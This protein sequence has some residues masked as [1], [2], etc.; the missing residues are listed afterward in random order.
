MSDVWSYAGKQC[1]VCGCTSGMGAATARELIDLGAEVTGL[2][3]RATEV[4]VKE[5]IPV[6]LSDKA[7]IDTALEQTPSRVDAL[8]VCSGL[9]G[10]TKW[11]GSEV[12]TVNFIGARHLVEVMIDKLADG[13]AV[14]SIASVAGMGFQAHQAEIMELLRAAST[15][16]D[17]A[18][19]CESHPELV[20][21]GYAFSK[22]CLI[23]YTMWRSTDLATRGVRINCI[24]PGPTD[25][26]MMP[27]FE[28]GYGK[29]YMQNFPKPVG[30]MSRPEEQAY[31][32]I[33][34]NSAAASYIT[35]VNLFTD[36]GFVGGLMTGA[37]DV[38]A[39]AGGQ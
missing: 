16:E 37:L 4:P 2:D 35:G 11:S 10:A 27:H 29:D 6:D 31:P 22:E 38:A 23:L 36:G 9:P 3:I 8:F 34:L 14:A 28:E 20:S 39:L 1:V 12:F 25:T 13:G 30:R 17:G 33:F 7:S 32:L 24:A 5:F 19:W 26:P 21:D 15:F 18:A